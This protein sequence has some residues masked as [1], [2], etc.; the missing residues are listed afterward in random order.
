MARWSHKPSRK[1][2]L[3]L[4]EALRPETRKN[5]APDQSTPGEFWEASWAKTLLNN[6]K[7]SGYETEPLQDGIRVLLPSQRS[8]IIE[9]DWQKTLAISVYNQGI[10]HYVYLKGAV[11]MAIIGVFLAY[12]PQY[13][14]NY[15]IL[16]IIGLISIS[17]IWAGVQFFRFSGIKIEARSW[18]K[19]AKEES[20][21]E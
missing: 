18:I 9:L 4:E 2:I 3:D 5:P 13:E 20:K 14:T 10:E 16:S 1:P 6:L 8:V 21:E 11:I 19:I 15:F 17:C 12:L 7:Q